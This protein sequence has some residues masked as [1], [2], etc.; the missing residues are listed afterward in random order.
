MARHR[1]VDLPRRGLDRG[2]RLI[3]G[4]GLGRRFRA[5][6]H[7]EGLCFLPFADR[8]LDAGLV[9][10][11]DALGIC[12][13][14]LWRTG[15]RPLWR[16][17]VVFRVVHRHPPRRVSGVGVAAGRRNRRISSA[18]GR[19]GAIRVSDGQCGLG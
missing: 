4:Q 15:E 7:G 6:H 9:G 1:R 19:L 3:H 10:L 13:R 14:G 12:L 2:L 11:L 18:R 5:V 16:A 17:P 8:D